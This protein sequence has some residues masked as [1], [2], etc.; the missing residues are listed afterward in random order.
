MLIQKDSA[1]IT[2]FDQIENGEVFTYAGD[3]FLKITRIRGHMII[4]DEDYD[5]GEYNAIR[6]STGN[7]TWFSNQIEVI[8]VDARLLIK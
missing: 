7:V 4:K 6:M 1:K 5:D 2:T 8:K 3:Y